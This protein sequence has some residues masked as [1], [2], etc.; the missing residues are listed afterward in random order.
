[1]SK[2]FYLICIFSKCSIFLL[3]LTNFLIGFEYKVKFLK[4]TSH[5]FNTLTL[6]L[7]SDRTVT[8][9]KTCLIALRYAH[10]I[11]ICT[12]ICTGFNP[13]ILF[14]LVFNP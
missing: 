5:H 8:D 4:N 7:I 13:K 3:I 10:V 9:K 14:V 12:C 1:M 11:I 2:I 6:F